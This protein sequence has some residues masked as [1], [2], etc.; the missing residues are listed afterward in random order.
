M[1]KLL[2]LQH[3]RDATPRRGPAQVAS[4]ESAVNLVPERKRVT[5]LIKMTAYQAK[6]DLLRTVTPHYCRV[7]IERRSFI[8]LALASSAHL[9]VAQCELRIALV[10][11]SSAHRTRAIAELR[12]E[13]NATDTTSPARDCERF[14]LQNTS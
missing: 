13:L 4:D 6:S 7:E 12:E 1:K 3:R 5:N 10:P 11:L 2:A 9:E 8:Q 14:A